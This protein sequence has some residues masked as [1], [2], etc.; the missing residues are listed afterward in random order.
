VDISVKSY[1]QPAIPF[2]TPLFSSVNRF[3]TN[4]LLC[5]D[6]P[7]SHF[8][9]S[10]FR[11]HPPTTIGSLPYPL[12]RK[13]PLLSKFLVSCASF[14]PRSHYLVL[15]IELVSSPCL[16]PPR[17]LETSLTLIAGASQWHWRQLRCVHPSILLHLRRSQPNALTTF[18]SF[19]KRYLF[20]RTRLPK[21]CSYKTFQRSRLV[22]LVGGLSVCR[23][24]HVSTC[25]VP[26]EL[27]PLQN[28]VPQTPIVEPPFLRCS[29]L[30][31]PSASAA[32]WLCQTSPSASS[33][34]N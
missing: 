30:T 18:S 1:E 13:L 7:P 21:P 14:A 12:Q 10:P 22:G 26:S 25:R 29:A 11:S 16:L 27:D 34:L 3:L 2:P 19:V 31:S 15:L 9:F 33:S 24:L 32:T 20:S 17:F 8:T 6:K 23:L 5:S 28:P 4:R